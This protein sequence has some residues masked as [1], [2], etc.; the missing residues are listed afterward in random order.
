MTIDGHTVVVLGLGLI[1]GSIARDCAGHGIP[2][3]GHD[4]DPATLDAAC[5]DGVVR[6]RLDDPLDDGLDAVLPEQTVVIVAGPVSATPAMLRDASRR[7]AGAALVMD[8]GSTKRDALAAAADAG[9]AQ[10]FVGS[11]PMA[12]DHRSGWSASR[13]GLFAGA[14]VY[15]CATPVSRADSVALAREFW[16]SLG[17]RPQLIDAREHD[18]RVAFA[19]HMPHVVSAALAI[20]MSKAGLTAADLGPGGR[21]VLRLAA[22]SPDVW[23]AITASNADLIAPALADVEAELAGFRRALEANDARALHALFSAGRAS[24][25]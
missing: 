19:S 1:G 20:A 3:V 13:R 17:G 8:V 22:S 21:D 12:G 4:S 18:E 16:T 2:V 10:R 6:V 15:L 14:T 11:H 9:V 25:R 24:M 7:F 5:A 23:S